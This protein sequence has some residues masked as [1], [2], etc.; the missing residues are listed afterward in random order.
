VEES[1]RRIDV[2][3]EIAASNYGTKGLVVANIGYSSRELYAIS[4]RPNSFYMLGSMGL[5]SSI[6]LGLALVSR[7][8][9]IVVIDGDGSVLMNLGT[10]ASIANFASDNYHLVIIDNHAHGSTGN[11][12]SL[13][14]MKTDLLKIS[15]GAGVRSAVRVRS[16]TQLIRLLRDQ[17]L[18]TVLIA[19]CTPYN[20]DVAP[21]PLSPIQI[22]NRFMK[23]VQPEST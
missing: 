13:T 7:R 16:R 5:A 10:L 1:L 14:A 17:S 3:R 20:A 15:A 11:Q 4:D 18:P 2:I 19:D 23:S 22:K 9:Q 12:S 6:G 21:V 8:Y